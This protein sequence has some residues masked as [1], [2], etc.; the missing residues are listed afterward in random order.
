MGKY[1]YSDEQEARMN[2]VFAD[3]VTE[4]KIQELVAEFDYPRRS[5][6]AKARKLGFDVPA[7][8]KAAPVFSEAQTDALVARLEAG[9]GSETA[10]QIAADFD[11]GQFTARQINGKALSLEMTGN[12]KPAEKKETPKTFTPEQEEVIRTM[13]ADGAFIEDIAEAVSKPVPS[14]RG[15]LLSMSLK[16][17]QRDHKQSKSDAYEGIAELCAGMS[18][19]ELADHFDKTPRG[20]RVVLTRRGLSAKDYEPK[21]K[22][23]A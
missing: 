8:P 18:V 2:T 7:K 16:A 12:I 20:V 1:N 17:P 14:V 22:S 23:A 3:G 4:E 6:T 11:G 21:E 5:V 10:E 13:V 9:D 19:D 15:K